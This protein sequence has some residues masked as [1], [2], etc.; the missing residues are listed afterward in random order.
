MKDMDAHAFALE[1][2]QIGI[3]EYLKRILDE[4]NT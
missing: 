1:R 3:A 4:K 2:V